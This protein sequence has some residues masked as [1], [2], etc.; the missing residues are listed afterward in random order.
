MPALRDDEEVLDFL[1]PRRHPMVTALVALLMAGVIADLDLHLPHG[2]PLTF[3][4]LLPMGLIGTVGSRWWQLLLA[5]A[6]CTGVAE[7]SDA[8]SWTVSSGVPRDLLTFIAF[9]AEA[10]YI[11]EA[12]ARRSVESAHVVTLQNENQARREIE[13]QLSLLIGSSALAI[14]TLDGDGLILQANDAA[15]HMFALDHKEAGALFGTPIAD[16]IP[17]MAKVPHRSHPERPVRTMM[18]TQ[19]FRGDGTPFLAEVWFSTYTTTHGPR[20]AAMIVDASE[21]LRDREE[22]ALEQLLSNS[23]MAVGAVA[24][25]IRNVTSAMQLVQRNLLLAAPSLSDTPDFQ[26]LQQLTWTLERIA[27][28]E[29]SHSKRTATVLPLQH[30]FEELRIVAQ[31][32][33]RENDIHFDW[34]VRGELPSVRADQ[35]GLMQV[36]LN[37]LGNARD[38]LASTPQARV[39]V[40]LQR[41]RQAVSIRISDNGPGVSVPDELFRPFWAD[42]STV[43]FGLYLSRAILHSFQGDITYE[44]LTPGASFVIT[45]Q[46][47][48]P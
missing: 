6:L 1:H 19:A 9:S 15:Q 16:F 8:F 18:Q 14:L 40:T 37:V 10:L 32:M 23:R 46:V 47:A 39:A 3:L 4:Y 36:F 17:S 11:H 28:V 43:S 30:C 7:A 29:T 42:P 22:A 26:A 25:E 35:H 48:Q 33:M 38:A 20:T 21:D 44:S 34:D 24:H 27:S 31:A 2:V 13:E 12:L 41:S 45:L 5:A